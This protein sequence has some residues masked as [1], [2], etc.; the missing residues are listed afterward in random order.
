MRVMLSRTGDHVEEIVT[1]RKQGTS[2]GVKRISMDPHHASRQFVMGLF[3]YLN[4]SAYESLASSYCRQRKYLGAGQ[5]NTANTLRDCVLLAAADPACAGGG[6]GGAGK[7]GLVSVAY[8]DGGNR[9]CYC[10]SG[11]DGCQGVEAAWDGLTLHRPW[12]KTLMT[13]P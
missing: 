6:G 8:E 4:P 13:A 5:H 11:T 9:N 2:F 1:A 12:I 10:G 3:G 7:A